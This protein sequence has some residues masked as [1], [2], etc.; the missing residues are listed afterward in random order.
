MLNSNFL[1]VLVLLLNVEQNIEF[2][3]VFLTARCVANFFA[4]PDAT[5][6]FAQKFTLLVVQIFATYSANG[7]HYM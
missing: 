5:P 4:T 6:E 1:F 2:F 7:L 3:T